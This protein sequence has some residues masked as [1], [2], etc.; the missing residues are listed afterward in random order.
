MA[1]PNGSPLFSPVALPVTVSNYI[2]V[3][4]LSEKL[5]SILQNVS[6]KFGSIS[7][8]LSPLC[9]SQMTWRCLSGLHYIVYPVPGPGLFLHMVMQWLC[10]CLCFFRNLNVL[11]Q[12]DFETYIPDMT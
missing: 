7:C 5:L 4:L 11:C 1:M 2:L 9:Q 3:D 8:D 6:G 10:L 12:Q